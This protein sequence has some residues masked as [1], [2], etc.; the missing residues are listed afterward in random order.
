M[1]KDYYEIL[2]VTKDA[3]QDEIKKKFRK[4]AKIFHPDISGESS[5]EE[6]IKEIVSA[7]EV[8]SDPD[9]RRNYDTQRR[10]LTERVFRPTYSYQQSSWYETCTGRRHTCECQNCRER[11]STLFM[12]I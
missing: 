2:D 12:Y 6:K 3:S 9:K 10:L 4:L 11:R 8:P 5:S 7:Y 1:A